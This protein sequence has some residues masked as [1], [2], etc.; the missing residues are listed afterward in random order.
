MSEIRPLEGGDMEAVAKLFLEILRDSATPP[1]PALTDYLR[2]HYFE[3][4]GND[5]EIRPLVHI[6]AGGAVTGFIGVN[7]LSLKHR[8]RKLRGAICG[9][10]MVKDHADNPLAGARLLKAVLAG[11][12]DVTL[13]ETASDVARR[14]WVNLRGVVLPQYSLEWVRILRPGSFLVD[15]AADRLNLLRFLAPFGR[16]LDRLAGW[17]G[18]SGD[19]QWSGLREGW[20]GEGGACAL[21]VDPATFSDLVEPLTEQFAL[22]PDWAEGQL[23]AILSA[24]R[25]KPS[26]GKL[27]LSTVNAPGG[28]PVGAFAYHVKPGCGARV[29]QILARPGKT[30]AVID[31]LIGDAFR[32]GASALRGRTQPAL[33]EAMLG[34]RIVFLN[35]SS[36]VV[37]SRDAEVIQSCRN[38]ELFFNGLAGEAWNRMIGGSFD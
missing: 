19:L 32:R 16:V 31:C 17:R 4:P 7:S 14:M 27:V 1:S 38:G 9:T 18:A 2:W 25:E 34:R 22:R 20:S 13:S 8:A 30:G 36:T 23:D 11:P 28:R 21:E 29:L 3:M 10:L 15:R 26:F 35:G 33:L 5:P 24:A 37:H 6:G 12:Q